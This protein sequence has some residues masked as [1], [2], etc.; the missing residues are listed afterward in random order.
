MNMFEL[1]ATYGQYTDTSK[2]P[3]S[4]NVLI[5]INSREITKMAARAKINIKNQINNAQK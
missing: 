4:G 3:I 1:T 5:P 2:M